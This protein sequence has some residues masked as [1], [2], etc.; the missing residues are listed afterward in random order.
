MCYAMYVK[1][2]IKNNFLGLNP[3]HGLFLGALTGAG[4]RIRP[5]LLLSFFV[6]RDGTPCNTRG[7]MI[8]SYSVH[9]RISH[10]L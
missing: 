6:P 10:V 5:P 9:D 2:L 4:G 7:G 3:K 8:I 1:Y